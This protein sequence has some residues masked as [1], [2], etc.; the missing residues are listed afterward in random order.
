M[1]EVV[2]KIEEFIKKDRLDF[3]LLNQILTDIPEK[4]QQNIRN[5][6]LTGREE[7]KINNTPISTSISFITTILSDTSTHIDTPTNQWKGMVFSTLFVI[8]ILIDIVVFYLHKNWGMAFLGFIGIIMIATFFLVY[9]KAITTKDMHK[10][11]T[12]LKSFWPY[13]SNQK[14]RHR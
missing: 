8:A 13:L 12:Y 14:S 10:I 6:I 2:E 9:E 3:N 7:V 1:I 5:C 4:H 11:L